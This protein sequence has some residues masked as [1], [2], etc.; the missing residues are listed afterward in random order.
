MK[1][2]SGRGPRERIA[3]L[4]VATVRCSNREARPAAVARAQRR[5]VW[6]RSGVEWEFS[7]TRVAVELCVT[8]VRVIGE[9]Y[10]SSS[11]L[12][13]F[14]WGTGGRGG[15]L[16]TATPPPPH[17]SHRAVQH[18]QTRSSPPSG[19]FVPMVPDRAID[20]RRSTPFQRP[21][22]GGEW[23]ID[24]GGR[25]TG[26][27]GGSTD[28]LFRFGHFS[29]PPPKRG[30]GWW[31]PGVFVWHTICVRESAGAWCCG[32]KPTATRVQPPVVGGKLSAVGVKRRFPAP[33]PPA[34]VVPHATG[35][36]AS[37]ALEP[38][39]RTLPHG[40]WGLSTIPHRD[41]PTVT[42]IPSD[43]LPPPL[44]RPS[45]AALDWQQA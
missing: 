29:V 19:L 38:V 34:V 25:V 41:G 39:R 5:V 16:G 33:R 45:V 42:L 40:V 4:K 22:D 36:R 26:R 12:W 17:C 9:H 31:A 35:P 11:G 2:H 15:G 1:P 10:R 44:H 8:C 37:R 30:G 24:G 43:P 20:W 21:L 32:W 28:A 14:I 27:A 7:D 3:D 13:L 23:L 6:R 18:P